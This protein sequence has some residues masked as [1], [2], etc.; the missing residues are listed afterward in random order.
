M[1]EVSVIVI[2]YNTFDLTCACIESIYKKTIGVTFEIILIDNA[3]TECS[4]DKFEALFPQIILIKNQ[5]NVGFSKGN[6][7]GIKKASGNIILLLNSDTELINNAIKITYDF[8]IKN[9][10]VAAVSSKLIYE[11]GL[12]QPC[13]QKFPSVF[14]N[15][16]EFSRIHRLLPGKIRSKLFFGAYF[17]HETYIQPDW[18]WGT[19]FMFPAKLLGML[20]DKK[21]NEDF[22]MY[23][24]DMQWCFE[25][26]HLGFDIAYL[27]DAI[28]LH[29]SGGS[30]GD[31]KLIIKNYN[32]FLK[33]NY[34]PLKYFILKQS[35]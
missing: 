22:F 5:S 27:P 6:N 8:L 9:P 20:K 34:N 3:S 4:P 16:I 32:S 19:F 2:N 23:V 11:N 10:H 29:H 12:I 17:N 21:L 24:E 30:S 25:F 15:L 13:C 33:K 26:R 31:I 1:P 28:V 14:N 7:I 35:V 18:I